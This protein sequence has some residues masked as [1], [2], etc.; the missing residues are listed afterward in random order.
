MASIEKKKRK[1]IDIQLKL[2]IIN[3]KKKKYVIG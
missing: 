2:D 1:V 3:D